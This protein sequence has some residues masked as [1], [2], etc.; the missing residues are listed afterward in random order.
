MKDG[1]LLLAAMAA[2]AM[3]ALV[4]NTAAVGVTPA[5]A[6]S[7][8]VEPAPQATEEP[9]DDTGGLSQEGLNALDSY[10]SSVHVEWTGTRADE[11]V[12][13]F[14]SVEMAFVREPRASEVTME[15]SGLGDVAEDGIMSMRYVRVGDQMWFYDGSS[16]SWTQM[17]AGDDDDAGFFSPSEMLPEINLD[18]ARRAAQTET[19]NDVEC[20]RY[21]FTEKDLAEEEDFGEIAKATG[22]LWEAVEGEFVVKVAMDAD[23][24][25]ME[26]DSLFD[27]GNITLLYEIHDINQPIVIEPP[28]DAEGKTGQREDI[29]MLPDAKIEFSMMGM[30]SYTTASTV[31]EAADFYKQEMPKN[32]WQAAKDG[33]T[34]MEDFVLLNYTKGSDKA[35]IMISSDD[36]KKVTNVMISLES[37]SGPLG[38]DAE[39]DEMG[40]DDGDDTQGGATVQLPDDVP[41]MPDARVDPTSDETY[42]VYTT[43]ASLKEI[44]SFYQKEMPAR[45]WEPEKDNDLVGNG[46]LDYSKDGGN[47]VVN[48]YAAEEDGEVTVDIFIIGLD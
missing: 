13:G 38:K 5:T 2:F 21:D 29:P 36:E 33:A 26:D 1:R 24:S 43:S 15:A 9:G 35:N 34:E 11:P 23:I 4:L 40:G 48:L 42:I 32:D 46:Y 28:A 47:R 17:P 22:T 7:P 18:P 39:M 37:E 6:A 27:K 44:E 25:A 3:L 8:Q 41:L 14:M 19:V 45:G 30:V 20:Y 16:D 31:K 12:E 10:R